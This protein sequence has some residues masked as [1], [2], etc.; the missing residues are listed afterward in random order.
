MINEITE[1]SKEQS[2]GIREISKAMSQLDQATQENSRSSE[3]VSTASLSMNQQ[4]ENLLNVV[5]SL[6]ELLKGEGKN[7]D[8]IKGSSIHS[9]ESNTVISAEDAS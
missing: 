8:P 6:E 5:N 4:V 7:I 2:K 3:E 9:N 1:A